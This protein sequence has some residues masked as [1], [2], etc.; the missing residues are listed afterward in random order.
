MPKK[1]TYSFAVFCK[2]V[3]MNVKHFCIEN[4][5]TLAQHYDDSRRYEKTKLFIKVLYVKRYLPV[6]KRA[7]LKYELF[8]I[9]DAVKL[10]C[11]HS[12]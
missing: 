5:Y 12:C 1:S 10:S 6:G 11:P 4:I 8:E 2:N 3:S 7:R 9:D